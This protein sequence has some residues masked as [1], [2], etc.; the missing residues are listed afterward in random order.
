VS[1]R[2]SNAG[3][4][5]EAM[6]ADAGRPID[7]LDGSILWE[8]FKAF[9]AIAI[10]GV[11]AADDGFLFDWR[12]QSRQAGERFC[13][14]FDRQFSVTDASGDYSHMEHVGCTLRFAPTKNLAALG[15]GH[16][17]FFRSES[18][19]T[20]DD[21]AYGVEASAAFA[22]TVAMRVPALETELGQERV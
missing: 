5:F 8:T 6:L 17:W 10:D 13:V 22:S 7:D 3:E 14:I 15:A 21:W 1:V 20:F 9:A 18:H 19:R 11:E 4:T 16:E 12:T 2:P